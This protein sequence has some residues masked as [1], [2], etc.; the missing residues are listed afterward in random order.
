MN[1]RDE[2][3][4]HSTAGERRQLLPRALAI[5]LV[6]FGF[7][8]IVNWIPGGHVAPWYADVLQTWLSGGAIVIGLTIVLLVVT[9]GGAL[10]A[11]SQV[12]ERAARWFA[13]RP[14]RAALIISAIA[15]AVYATV[16]QLVFDARPLFIDEIVQLYQ[17]RL[18]A[19]G[20]LTDHVGFFPEFFGALN[21]VSLGDRQFGQFPPGG[22]AHL[23]LG[24]LIGAPW[25]VTPLVGGAAVYVF[26]LLVR[27]VEPEAPVAL[28][29]ML[30]FA[31]SP[32]MIF[33]SASHMNHVPTLLWVLIAWLACVRMITQPFSLWRWSLLFG[34]AASIA[35]SIRPVDAA[36]MIAPALL[37]AIFSLRGKRH[38]A[39]AI[40]AVCAGA[41]VPAALLLGYNYATTGSPLLF[42]YELM[43]GKSHS[44]G[45]HNSPWGAAH[46]PARGL[47]LLSLYLLR[48][49]SYLFETPTPSL[50]PVIATLALARRI[51]SFDKAMLW[52]AVLLAAAYFAYWHDGFYLGP[53]FFFVLVPVLALF[54][55][56]AP[57]AVGHIANSLRVRRVAFLGLTTAILLGICMGIPE[58]AQYYARSLS[59]SRHRL[60]APVESLGVRNALIFVRESWGSQVIARLWGRGIDRSDA[61]ALYRAVDTCVLDSALVVLEQQDV[62]GLPARSALWPLLRDSASVQSSTLSPDRSERVLSGRTYPQRC[63]EHIADDHRGVALYPLLL[64]EPRSSNIFVR[65][66]GE[67][68]VM[69]TRQY[70][71]R[72]AYLLVARAPNDSVYVLRPLPPHTLATP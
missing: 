29:A 60:T 40:G 56:R 71:H 50:I 42:G 24:V 7:L 31:F 52:A 68:N 41:A 16:A 22:P 69:L 61:E 37:L 67:R 8:P 33:M 48:L 38:A 54:A 70:P 28:A 20:Q 64:A 62:R 58:R 55:A 13:A 19:V 14:R 51:T 26:G 57:R 6:A 63:L 25:L 49:Q 9:R 35:A 36:A 32:F 72:A 17:A 39:V 18:F 44:L 2:Q 10:T 59:N 5:A 27:R 21:V 3:A 11:A 47:E 15:A 12:A 43:W 66:L 65:D 34:I 1:A 4:D 46:S 53:R 45:F 23:L 30:L